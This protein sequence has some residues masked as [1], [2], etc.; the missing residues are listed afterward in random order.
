MTVIIIIS[1]AVSSKMT[2]KIFDVSFD[3]FKNGARYNRYADYYKLEYLS[4]DKSAQDVRLYAQKNLILDEVLDKCYIPFA[5]G[6]KREKG[7]SSKNN[8]IMLLL[9]A[10]T[11]GF[12]YILV[13]AK[14]INGSIGIGNVLLTYSCCYNAYQGTDRFCDDIY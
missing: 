2:S 11:G 1:A 9:S 10:L 4:D 14:A 3:V 5:E 13:G 8:G 12:V 7:A 6:D